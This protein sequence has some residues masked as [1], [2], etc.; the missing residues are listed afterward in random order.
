LHNITVFSV[1]LSLGEHKFSFANILID[2]VLLT[3]SILNN[4]EA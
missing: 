3:D 2:S 1:F 4:I